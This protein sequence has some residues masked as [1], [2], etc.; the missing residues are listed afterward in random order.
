[1]LLVI[2]GLGVWAFQ[3]MGKV[4]KAIAPARAP[5]SSTGPS[6]G[7]STGLSTR[8]STAT[9]TTAA[10]PVGAGGNMQR[11]V[12]RQGAILRAEPKASGDILKRELKGAALALVSQTDDGWS[13][14]KDGNITGW[15]RTSVLGAEPPK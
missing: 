10:A 9:P 15:M 2:G 5:V 1:V 6:T 12:H 13:Q 4:E 11:F 14:V 8:A 7:L 3:H